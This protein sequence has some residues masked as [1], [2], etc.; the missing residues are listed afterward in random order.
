M[1]FNWNP[2]PSTPSSH[3]LLIFAHV[4]SMINSLLP[5]SHF[6]IPCFNIGVDVWVWGVCAG[7]HVLRPCGEIVLFVLVPYLEWSPPVVLW[8]WT[9]SSD[10]VFPTAHNHTLINGTPLSRVSETKGCGF[11]PHISQQR[12]LIGSIQNGSSWLQKT[13]CLFR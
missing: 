12:T 10:L 13:Q 7:G 1:K 5:L 9:T 3:Y 11:L 2:V 4:I 8:G 6:L